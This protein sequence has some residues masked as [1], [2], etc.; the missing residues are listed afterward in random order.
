[1]NDNT[2]VAKSI[3]PVEFSNLVEAVKSAL[4]KGDPGVRLAGAALDGSTLQKS[5]ASA[6]ESALSITLFDALLKGW[7]GA[8]A[9][10]N[11]IGED[12]PTDDKPRVAGL[13]SHKLKVRYVPEIHLSI[14][15]LVDLRKVSI[16]ITLEVEATGV[17]LTVVNRKITA[18]TAGY[19]QPKI[20]VMVEK[21]KLA[22][23]KLQRIELSGNLLSP[24]S[25][26]GANH[27][28]GAIAPGVAS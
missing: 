5:V 15:D 13:A 16:P 28:A 18:A 8:K 24:R 1:M 22:E 2:T 19:L 11:L 6:V 20:T 23:T 21:V 9:I 17:A 27:A 14:G 10:K 4:T 26:E 7:Y 25:V 3:S 12:G